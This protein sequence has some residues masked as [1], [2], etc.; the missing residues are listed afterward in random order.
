MHNM[1]YQESIW[2]W[3]IVHSATSPPLSVGGRSP[4]ACIT[5]KRREVA[6]SPSDEDNGSTSLIGVD[7][8]SAIAASFAHAFGTLLGFE[9][10]A[11]S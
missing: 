11:L 1:R 3:L 4:G 6:H 9:L 8:A 2:G 7:R 10:D 5:F